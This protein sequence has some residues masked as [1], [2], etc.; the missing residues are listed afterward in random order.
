M[1][2]GIV[3]EVIGDFLEV[4]D[5]SCPE[6][7]ENVLDLAGTPLVLSLGFL[8]FLEGVLRKGLL[9]FVLLVADELGEGDE[10]RFRGGGGAGLLVEIGALS[11]IDGVVGGVEIVELEAGPDE[12]GDG[13]VL[14]AGG[15]LLE[16]LAQVIEVLVHIY[17][18]NNLYGR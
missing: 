11:E 15:E 14:V 1:Q 17:P 3:E 8:G 12:L 2:E 18:L 6:T 5:H 7:H 9:G 13:V 10:G 4:S 16:E